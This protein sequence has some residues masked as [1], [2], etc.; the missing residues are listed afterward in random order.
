MK[1]VWYLIL[2]V[3]AIACKDVTPEE[4]TVEESTPV[5]STEIFQIY[6]VTVDNLRLRVDQDKGSEV[7]DKLKESSL[8]Y[9]AGD[10]SL[11]QE[12]I[13]LR[14]KEWTQPYRHIWNKDKSIE[15][16]SYGGGLLKIYQ[17]GEAAPFTERFE[18]IPPSLSSIDLKREDAPMRVIQVVDLFLSSDPQWNSALYL[19]ARNYFKMIPSNYEVALP[20]DWDMADF[21]EITK[22][23]FNYDKYVFSKDLKRRGF[24]IV[25]SEGMLYAEPNLSLLNNRFKNKVNPDINKFLTIETM[26][27][28]KQ[29]LDDAT[30]VVQLENLVDVCVAY[31]SFQKKG[32]TLIDVN[33]DVPYDMLMGLLQNGVDNDPV[34]DQ[35]GKVSQRFSEAWNYAAEKY[36]D[37]RIG[38]M[39]RIWLAEKTQS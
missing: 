29:I 20:Q 33:Q 1:H 4:V 31:D 36:P 38:E 39:A 14:G 9:G 17:S 15:G 2:I 5:E 32:S 27:S 37:S 16:W 24:N 30:I 28:G 35:D 25:S 19:M 12:T 23:T 22:G 6:M 18:T 7:T 21:M 13:T 11:K 3:G 34:I 8:M 10:E 26:Y